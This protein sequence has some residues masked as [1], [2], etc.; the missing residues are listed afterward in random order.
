MKKFTYEEVKEYVERDSTVLLSLEY[1]DSRTKLELMCPKKH[2]YSNTLDN[3]KNK[4]QRC[5]KCAGLAKPSFKEVKAYV[6]AD[7][8]TLLSF[9]YINAHT[10]LD[11]MCPKKHEYS[12]TPHS[13]KNGGHRCPVCSKGI[14][15]KISQ[16]WLDQKDKLHLF[17]LEREYPIRIG[18][19]SFR[20][21]GYDPLTRTIYEFLGNY[22]HGNLVMYDPN[23][24]NPTSKISYGQLH[25]ETFERIAALEAAGYNVVYI[26]ESALKNTL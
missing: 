8:T 7:G 1:V 19:R 21:D 14:V 23:D 10:P 4:N 20:V 16:A 6:E 5:P 15:S 2:K 18:K 24:I 11:F 3:F 22:W 25:K 9:E 13:F 26:W 12:G 17:P